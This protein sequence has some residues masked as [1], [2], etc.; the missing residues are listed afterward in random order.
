[1]PQLQ[2]HLLLYVGNRC[3]ATNLDPESASTRQVAA[4]APAA[5]DPQLQQLI[6]EGIDHLMKEHTDWITHHIPQPVE[7]GQAPSNW[8]G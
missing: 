6:D 8:F 3:S 7:V 4:N 5:L 2:D 1:M